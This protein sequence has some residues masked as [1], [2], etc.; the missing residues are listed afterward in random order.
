MDS[1]H[2]RCSA[3]HSNQRNSY[4]NQV[5]FFTY[6]STKNLR[7]IYR[8]VKDMEKW[9]LSP[10][11]ARK[12]K[13]GKCYRHFEGPSASTEM[14]MHVG[15]GIQLTLEQYGFELHGP[16]I[17]AFLSVVN[18]AVLLDPWLVESEDAEPRLQRE[19]YKLHLDFRLW[20]GLVSL[21]PHYSRVS[22]INSI[23]IGLE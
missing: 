16:H 8:V 2:E 10:T 12:N 22:C 21:T 7:F 19:N 4:L 15:K 14:F 13:T 11:I 18:T 17:C 6:Q 9:T 20:G 5:T 23:Y 3:L 1:K